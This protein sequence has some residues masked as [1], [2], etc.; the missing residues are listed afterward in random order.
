MKD[1]EQNSSKQKILEIRSEK[2]GFFAIFLQVIGNLEW[3]EKNNYKP[4]VNFSDQ[5]CLYW[6]EDGYRGTKNAWEYYFEN[7]SDYC[8]ENVESDGVEVL[9]WNWYNPPNEDGIGLD[10][11]D[12]KW[13]DEPPLFYRKYVNKLIVKYIRIKDY[14]EKQVNEFFAESMNN[15]KICG[16]HVRRTDSVAD[17]SK[18]SP[19]LN[20]YIKEVN[21]YIKHVELKENNSKVKVFLATDDAKVLEEFRKTFGNRLIYCDFTRSSSGE[22][23]HISSKVNKPKV[24]EEVLIECLLLS[25]CDFLI[26]SRSNVSSAA[27]YINPELDHIY[28]QPRPPLPPGIKGLYRYLNA[29]LK[30][31]LS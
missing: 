30:L 7:V 18:R 2:A 16:V 20:Q 31:R 14:I 3:C 24:G 4:W 12:S 6:V 25:K 1:T 13:N 8:P 5:N 9:T 10:N 22:A 29:F 26:H 27:L 19:F 17:L 11:W 15:G 28:I 21:H 23:L